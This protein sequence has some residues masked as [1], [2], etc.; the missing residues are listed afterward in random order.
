MAFS[1]LETAG[2]GHSGPL[3]NRHLHVPTALFSKAAAWVRSRERLQP[4]AWLEAEAEATNG[5]RSGDRHPG[6][7]E[8]G[9]GVGSFSGGR[10]AWPGTPAVIR[11]EPGAV[12]PRGSAGDGVQTQGTPSAR[13]GGKKDAFSGQKGLFV[14]VGGVGTGLVAS[15]TRSS[16]AH[17]SAE[18]SLNTVAGPWH[19]RC[20]QRG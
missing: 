17:G 7:G 10:G 12:C 1:T 20:R 18:P 5:A 9:D 14:V 19:G 3:F 2:L 8:A 6:L 11:D 13:P 4:A 16:V 15:R